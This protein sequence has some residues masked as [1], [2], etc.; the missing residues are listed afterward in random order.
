[1]FSQQL[2]SRP[3]RCSV[4][5]T[6]YLMATNPEKAK[7]RIAA[8]KAITKMAKSAAKSIDQEIITIPVVVHVIYRTKKE[9]ISKAQILSQMEVLNE[10]F[11]RMNGNRDNEWS[12]AADVQVEFC[13]ATVDPNGNPTDGITRTK[14]DV[15]KW[16]GNDRMKSS[17]RGGVDPWD[18]EQY[19]NMWVCNYTGLGYSSFPGESGTIDGVV[20]KTRTFGSKEKGKEFDLQQYYDLGRTTTHEVGHF[21]GLE[22]I[23]GPGDEGCGQD[24]FIDDTPLAEKAHTSPS[25]GTQRSC[26]SVDMIQNYM[27]YSDDICMNLF[28]KGQKERMRSVL[29]GIRSKLAN[30][31]KCSGATT[32]APPAS[33]KKPEVSFLN[34]KGNI[35]VKEGYKLQVDVMA[36][37]SDGTIDFVELFID[38][39]LIRKEKTA[40]YNWGHDKSPNPEELN[41]LSIGKHRIK[42]VAMDNDGATAEIELVLTVRNENDREN[43]EAGVCAFGAP[44]DTAL[45]SFDKVSYKNVTVLG[46]GP[47]LDMVSKFRI[48]WNANTG[49][50]KQFAANTKSAPYY[51]DL[52]SKSTQSFG[53][54]T[55]AVLI[56]DSAIGL[57]GDF[58]V[59]KDGDNFVMTAKD[60]AYT[61]YFSNSELAPNCEGRDRK[62]VLTT[63]SVF[64]NPASEI[65]YVNGV[66]ADSISFVLYD[67]SGKEI[68]TSVLEDGERTIN[69]SSINNGFYL[70]KI[71]SKNGVSISSSLVIDRK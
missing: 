61:L 8:R 24:D 27:D 35:A 25:C 37:D 21:L 36:E 48:N 50:L 13:L 51:H 40:P 7:K 69:V 9:N 11:R 19:L 30:S 4:K 6:D 68:L 20:M 29:R 44:S 39:K 45:P 34:P 1:M 10:D 55:P 31:T 66:I 26:G 5:S 62:E 70:Y 57:D 67:M 3:T 17:K 43:P 2:K 28:T 53:E 71:T 59:V 32:P 63:F 42:A 23:W 65:V 14:T 52:K 41:G 49:E 64:P 38:N 12:Q 54:K 58:W 18:V 22:H 56:K 16:N 47:N 60:G 46:D 15:K 33:N